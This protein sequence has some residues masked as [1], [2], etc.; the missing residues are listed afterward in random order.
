MTRL[1]ALALRLY[2]RF[3]NA[4]NWRGRY[5]PS[6]WHALVIPGPAGDIP[7]RVHDAH[8]SANAPVILYL[9]GGGWVIGD[10]DTHQPFCQELARQAG[11]LV[12]AI[13][14]RLAPEHRYPAAQEDCL[15]AAEWLAGHLDELGPNNGRLVIGGDSAGGHLTAC[16]CLALSADA[17]KAIAGAVLLYPVVDHYSNARPSYVERAN[18]CAL[19]TPLMQWFIDTYLGDTAPDDALSAR[20]LL[21]TQLASLPPVFS[22]TAEYDPLRDE[23]REFATAVAAAGVAVQQ[24][25]FPDAA[26]GFACGEGPRQDHRELMADL[27][28]WLRELG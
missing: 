7:A 15:A 8:A 13:D 1:K 20:P 26:H 19:T 4:R 3:I 6:A 23:G 12:V 28:G 21:S 5:Q 27:T 17:R 10:L 9:H 22:A 2:Y 25:H 24:R 14:Y 11:A 18:A 16:T